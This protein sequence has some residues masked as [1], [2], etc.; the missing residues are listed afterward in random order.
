MD[1]RLIALLVLLLSSCA[2]KRDIDFE[3]K[4]EQ[5]AAK[6]YPARS[7]FD[8]RLRSRSER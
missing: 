8:E 1:T 7:H 4:V 3:R 6:N 5:K 2:A